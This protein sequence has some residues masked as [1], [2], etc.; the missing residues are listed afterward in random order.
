M[1]VTIYGPVGAVDSLL[2]TCT[3]VS[4]HHTLQTTLYVVFFLSSLCNTC[5]VIIIYTHAYEVHVCMSIE[6]IF[7]KSLSMCRGWEA[8]C[9]CQQWSY[10]YLVPY[11]G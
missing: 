2:G 6:Y 8:I 9:T 1:S 4:D 10:L 5:C 7:K 11:Y 3:V